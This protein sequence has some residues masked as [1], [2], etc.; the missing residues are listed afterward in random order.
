MKKSPNQTQKISLRKISLNKE[1]LR[2]LSTREIG[3]V[4]GGSQEPTASCTFTCD[5]QCA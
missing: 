2:L 3:Q 5:T 1:T 4:M